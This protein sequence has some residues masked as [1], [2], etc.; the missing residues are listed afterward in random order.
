LPDC[1]VTVGICVKNNED[2]IAE[3]VD[4]V[5]DQDFQHDLMELIIVDGCSHDRTITII[6]EILSKT[7]IQH[8]I[9]SEN[10]GLGYARQIVVDNASG[11]YIVWVDGDIVLTT[12][13]IRSQVEF[14]DSHPRVGILA[15]RF[16]LL[17]DNWVA[18]LE[19]IG[20][21]LY[22]SNV[23]PGFTSKLLGTEASVQRTQ[24]IR[25]VGGFDIHIRGAAEDQDLSSRVRSAGWLMYENRH[26]FYER[27]R[28]TWKDLWKQHYWYGYG[29]HYVT[30]KS[31]RRQP[32]QDASN[33]RA[34]FSFAAYRA[35]HKKVV[36]LLPLNFVF[37]KI[38]L[39]AGFL[40]AHVTGYGHEKSNIDGTDN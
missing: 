33:D 22:D 34:I 31:T 14:M 23:K 7:D 16:G 18:L 19:N 32:I 11:T 35:T 9:F 2:T 30:H 15:G 3:A 26:I 10:K 17:E 37:K 29:L 6:K 12:D 5:V 8:K 21:V 27:Q 20:N 40:G 25:E 36:F 39:F 24:A 4:H 38:A 13:Y 28:R 1:K